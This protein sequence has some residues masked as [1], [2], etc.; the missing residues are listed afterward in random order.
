MVGKLD[1]LL[2]AQREFVADASHQLRTPL[3]ALRLRL[4]NLE[5]D[6]GTEGQRELERPS[7]R[8]E[9]LSR[10][11]TGSSCSPAPTKGRDRP[12]RST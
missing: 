6:L 8:C 5:H 7:A 1:G 10:L 4:E 3:T 9:R 2:R 12:K 11:V